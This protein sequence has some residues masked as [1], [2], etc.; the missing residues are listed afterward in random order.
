[1]VPIRNSPVTD[2]SA[3]RA[4]DMADHRR[5]ML[6]F[7]DEQL[8]EIDEQILRVRRLGRSLN[9]TTVDDFP[10]RS[11][12]ENLA[13]LRYG[14]LRA[15]GVRLVRGL[16]VDR[17]SDEEVG[18][19]FWG[20]GAHL[21]TGVSQNAEGDRLG[22]VYDQ[23]QAWTNPNVRGYQTSGRLP[24]HCDGSDVVGLLCLRKAKTG[25]LSSVVSAMTIYNQILAERPEYLGLLYAGYHYDRRGEQASGE[26]SVSPKVPIFSYHDGA[27]SCRYLRDYIV[28]GAFRLGM[29][30]SQLELEMFDHF[31]TLANDPANRI[32]MDL[33]P[34]DIQLCNNYTTLHARTA[35]VD[36]PEPARRRHM[37]RLWLNMDDARPLAPDFLNR[38][39]GAGA[40]GRDGIAV[41]SAQPA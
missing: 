30:L 22:H 41:K 15:E 25:G 4:D 20:L 39:G 32:E 31:D 6:T 1:M 8:A 38:Y 29:D 16:P 37:L 40:D 9:E 21:G 34:G 5:W 18:Q 12:R 11:L 27:L 3:W 33:Q 17:Y 28:L 2:A 7:S 24:F 10:L 35:Y 36:W 13:A 23:G 19:F 26:R 14:V